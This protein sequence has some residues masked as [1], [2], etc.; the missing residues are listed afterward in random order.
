MKLLIISDRPARDDQLN[1]VRLMYY[2]LNVDVRLSMFYI[3][4]TLDGYSI[5]RITRPT[6]DGVL[7]NPNTP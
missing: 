2:Q 1:A 7:R 5:L 4:E 6:I 3:G